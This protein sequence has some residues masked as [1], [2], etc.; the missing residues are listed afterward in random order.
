[1]DQ[2]ATWYGSLDPGDIVLDGDPA[3]PTE[4]GKAATTFRPTLLWH[5]RPTRRYASAG[6]S[7]CPVSVCPSV[8]LSQVNVLL[9][10]LNVGSRKERYTIG[11]GI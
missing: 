9:K 3:L 2:D 7:C 1:M 4:R 10:R 6:I 8:H 11:Q 5:G